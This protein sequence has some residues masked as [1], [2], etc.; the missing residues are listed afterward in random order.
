MGLRDVL[1]IVQLANSVLR[2]AVCKRGM[3]QDTGGGV[4]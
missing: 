1:N 2:S 4:E 3:E